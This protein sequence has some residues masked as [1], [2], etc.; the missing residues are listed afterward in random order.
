M[1]RTYQLH[2]PLSAETA[3]ALLGLN[4]LTAQLLQNRGITDADTART[5]LAPDYESGRHDPFLLPDMEAAVLRILRAI[6][7]GERIAIYADYDCDGIPGAVLMHDFF[8]AI[9][10]ANV[11]HYI[12]HR[13]F[14]GFGFN[15][16]A[17]TALAE[18]A[19]AL[20]ITID[21]GTGDD[22]A[23]A[24][25]KERGIDVIVTDHH[26][27][28]AK[29]DPNARPYALVNPKAGGAYPFPDLCG[30]GVA[31]KLV[32]ALIARGPFSLTPGHEKW[33]LDMVGM[34]TIGDMVPLLGEN[35]VFAKY[36]LTVLRKS[37][38]PGIRHLLRT[39][40]TSQQHLTEDDIG[41]TIGPRIN[42]AS[43]MD[44]PDD[45]FHMLVAKDEGDAGAR[46]RHLERLNNER[47]G[48][49]AAMTKD[50]KKRI[51][52]LA[53]LPDVIVMGSPEWRP[54]LA[55]LAANG[56]AEAY[57]RPAFVWGRDGNGIIKGSCRSEG[58]TS[59]AALMQ[60]V[61]GIFIEH[62]GHHM[63]GG[64]S[65]RDEHVFTFGDELN[66]AYRTLG[67]AAAVEERM[68]VD[69]AISFDDITEPFLAALAELAPFGVGNPKPLFA[70]RD[71]MP[72]SVAQFGKTKEHLKLVFDTSRG[73]M[74]AIA[75]FA[76]PD[77]YAVPPGE[78][79]P[80]TLLAHVE[81]SYFMNR[82]QTRLRIVDILP[83]GS[84]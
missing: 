83:A 18:D 13:H 4:A 23:V 35:R 55:G 39:T 6:K 48:L 1:P 60:A 41:F 58:A 68:M 27:P 42:A 12:P 45:A 17:V 49:V 76:S 80:C 78:G 73:Q 16:D 32:E 79:V 7:D 33:W 34:A 3:D 21:C 40:R 14:E 22:A 65:V 20:I 81:R 82:L 37:R 47:K 63:S 72:R 59:V 26:L 31:F 46:V 84:V 64:F 8:A 51:S 29:T 67:H 28:P 53:E 15:A 70:F 50:L 24:A 75:F 74:E 9:G 30:A 66:V 43:R 57:R 36:G 38:R 11:R 54:A 56:L 69:A 61:S 25:A 2:D 5:F 77:A 62:G 10:Y 19:V 44:V 52:E 71:V